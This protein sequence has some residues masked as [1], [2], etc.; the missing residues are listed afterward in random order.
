MKTLNTVAILL[1]VFLLIPAGSAFARGGH[2]DYRQGQRMEHRAQRNHAPN[3]HFAGNR[4]HYANKGH[5][6]GHGYRAPARAYHNRGYRQYHHRGYHNPR[7]M[8]HWRGWRR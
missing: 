2:Q 4:Q 3:R 5:F 7:V 1:A 6:R 8:R